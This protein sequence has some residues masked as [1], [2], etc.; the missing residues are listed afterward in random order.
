MQGDGGSFAPLAL[1]LIAFVLTFLLLLAYEL[2]R[3]VLLCIWAVAEVKL[4][5]QERRK[6]ISN[7]GGRGIEAAR[8]KVEV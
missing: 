5:W 6:E 8:P 4:W 3:L 1:M 7:H 2:H